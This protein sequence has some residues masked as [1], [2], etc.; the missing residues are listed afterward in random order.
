LA[1]NTSLGVATRIGIVR[2]PNGQDTDDNQADFQYQTVT[3]GAANNCAGTGAGQLL[4]TSFTPDPGFTEAIVAGQPL[5]NTCPAGTSA[6]TGSD[7]LTN[8][9]L[10]SSYGGRDLGYQCITGFTAGRPVSFSYYASASTSNGT[11]T[12]S[13]QAKFQ[14][15]YG[16]LCT[17]GTTT[18]SG[19]AHIIPQGSYIR[20]GYTSIAPTNA[21]GLRI[22]LDLQDSGGAG[23]GVDDRFCADDVTVTSR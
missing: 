20:T 8:A 12:L 10:T 4:S 5:S 22:I 7:G 21:T 2:C 9:S 17:P 13:G 6:R 1:Q 3:I 15:Y 23:A 14:W 16:G 11:N 19:G 18:D